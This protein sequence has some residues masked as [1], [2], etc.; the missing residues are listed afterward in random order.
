MKGDIKFPIP[1]MPNPRVTHLVGEADPD[2]TLIDIQPYVGDDDHAPPDVDRGGF[3]WDD[4]GGRPYGVDEHPELTTGLP[5][6]DHAP[7][8]VDRDGFAEPPC[9]TCTTAEPPGPEPCWCQS[10]GLMFEDGLPPTTPVVPVT[11]LEANADSP[12]LEAYGLVHGSRQAKY[13]HPA[14]DFARTAALWRALFGW[15]VTPENVALA[16]MCVKLSR[17][18]A[19]PDHRDSVVDLAGYAETYQ[20]VMERESERW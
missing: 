3:R 5:W 8:R 7:L 20:M 1:P 12:I 19:T 10:S 9:G 13:G 16:M 6:P 15:N 14:D 17:L 18:Q 11:D 4:D 2:V